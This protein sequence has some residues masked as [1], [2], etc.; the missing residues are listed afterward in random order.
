MRYLCLTNILGAGPSVSC[1]AGKDI[2]YFLELIQSLVGRI[3]FCNL[4][5][6]EGLYLIVLHNLDRVFENNS[7]NRLLK[8]IYI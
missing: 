8:Q 5:A 7:D 3:L 2:Q 6:E 1:R 4:K